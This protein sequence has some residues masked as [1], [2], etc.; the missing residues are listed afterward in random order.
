ME[1]FVL[2]GSSLI[3]VEFDTLFKT[4]I[5]D[6]SDIQNVYFVNKEYILLQYKYNF[7]VI[8]ASNIGDVIE[9]RNIESRFYKNQHYS[10]NID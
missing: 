4:S 1:K 3:I 9:N 7:K 10:R 5:E 8:H 6:A 2:L